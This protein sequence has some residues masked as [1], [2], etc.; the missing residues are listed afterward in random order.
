[1]SH[2]P[3]HFRRILEELNAGSDLSQRA[4]AKRLGIALGHANQLLRALVDREWVRVSPGP[5]HRVR[6]LVTD[7]GTEALA[8]MTRAHLNR[9]VAHYGTVR[10]RIRERLLAYTIDSAAR[11]GSS[12]PP[13]VVLYGAGHVAEIAYTC[14]VDAGVRL[15]AVIDDGRSHSF[16]GLPVKAS[17]E[18]KSMV[19]DGQPFDWLLVACLS[20]EHGIRMRLRETG[21]PLDRVTWL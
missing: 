17:T 11:G 14:A 21:F 15:V 7:A 19:L 18:L 13:A 3:D 2:N 5:G 9:A 1:M 10:N 4:L 6:Y 16:L 12:T 8:E 20:D